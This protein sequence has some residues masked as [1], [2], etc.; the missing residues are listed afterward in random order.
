MA[1][2]RSGRDAR[3]GTD[4]HY[5][6]APK[7]SLQGG[8]AEILEI[9][10]EFQQKEQDKKKNSR[11]GTLPG[12]KAREN[13]DSRCSKPAEDAPIWGQN[14]GKWEPGTRVPSLRPGSDWR[15]DGGFSWCRS[16]MARSE[17]HFHQLSKCLSSGEPALGI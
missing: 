12:R 7:R 5:S 13:T 3:S 1:M 16:R 14:G 9:P 10:W 4:G 8:F 2:Q 17:F 6:D 15:R 11:V